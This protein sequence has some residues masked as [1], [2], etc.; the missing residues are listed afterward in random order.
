MKSIQLSLA[1]TFSFLF[2][3]LPH[4]PIACQSPATAPTSQPV[5]EKAKVEPVKK[6]AEKNK[7]VGIGVLNRTVE[8]TVYPNNLSEYNGKIVFNICIDRSGKILYATHNKGK[9]T[10][11]EEDAISE[12][13]IAMKKTKFEANPSTL[14]ER[15]CGQWTMKFD[16]N[17]AAK[18]EASE[19]HSPTIEPFKPKG[20]EK[21]DR[22]V[23][24]R[25]FPKKIGTLN[26]YITFNICI[27]R[28][29]NVVD[30]KYNR[31]DSSI[32]DRDAIADTLKSMK[33][34]KFEADSSA[35]EN[36][37]GQWTMKF[38]SH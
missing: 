1:F 16:S 23:I 19:H 2:I 31:Q 21:P 24:K 12:A 6:T 18:M 33:K 28:M 11:S 9:S 38:E 36:D 20:L 5:S 3:G 30:A 4:N 14:H 25:V 22:A 13:L 29:G 8:K 26:G 35:Q 10:I 37:C 15:E 17:Q 7:F 32:T 34:T 27:D